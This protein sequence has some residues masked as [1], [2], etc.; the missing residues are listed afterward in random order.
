M[1]KASSGTSWQEV[2]F[3]MQA[4]SDQ[5]E[6]LL[7]RVEGVDKVERSTLAVDCT[8][9]DPRA[10]LFT[11]FYTGQQQAHHGGWFNKYRVRED[12]KLGT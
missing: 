5:G 9:A 12:S 1:T 3:W 6:R 7:V 8:E 4:W 2:H 10:P 11:R